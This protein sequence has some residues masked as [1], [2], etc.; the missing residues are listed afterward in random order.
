MG[1][2][3]NA[4]IFT[5][6]GC[7]GAGAGFY[8]A[9]KILEKRMDTELEEVRGYYEEEKEKVAADL[10]EL[11]ELRNAQKPA[12]EPEKTEKPKKT[13]KKAK[14]EA[15]EI[16]TR[17]D[18][19]EISKKKTTSKKK[20]ADPDI[21]VITAEDFKELNG[22]DKVTLTYFPDEDRFLDDG[23]LDYDSGFEEIGGTATIDQFEDGYL[24][25][26]N[27][28]TETDYEVIRELRSFKRYLAEEV[29][30]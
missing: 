4:F 9:K 27:R 1:I 17:M 18:Y 5:L 11:E 23:N 3:K 28:F 10:K 6:G 21:F 13:I 8:A 20:A 22:Y 14:E 24:Y 29:G 19:A 16:I 30:D 25:V 26:R 7:V 15:E 2:L 12:E